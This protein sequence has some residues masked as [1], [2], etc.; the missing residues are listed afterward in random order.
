MFRPYGAYSTD[1][2]RQLRSDLWETPTE[3]P[4]SGL[5]THAYLWKSPAGSNILFYSTV[6]DAA[7]DALGELG[8]VDHQYLSHQDEAGPMLQALK[9]RFHTIL[10]APKGDESGISQHANVDVWLQDRGVDEHYVE[11][12][13]T[14]G[15]TPGSTCFVV[16]GKDGDVYLFTGDTIYTVDNNTWEAG[17]LRSSN[18]EDLAA[19]L[20]LL[21][22]LRPTL[23]LSSAAPTGTGAHELN[24]PAEWPALVDVALENL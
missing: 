5:K 18:A 13:P 16:P 8:G 4:F 15:H 21:A 20:K 11:I 23:V 9:D 22:T 24:D 12:I 7:F 17:L 6:T 14:P 19:T 2:L 1:M 3:S 10:H